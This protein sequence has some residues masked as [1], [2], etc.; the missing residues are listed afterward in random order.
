MTLSGRV[1][2]FTVVSL[3]GGK[4]SGVFEATDPADIQVLD[5][6]VRGRRGV[7]E[8]SAEIYADSIE[9]KKMTLPSSSSKNIVRLVRPQITPPVAMEE[10]AGVVLAAEKPKPSD[11]TAFQGDRDARSTP[12]IAALMQGRVK[13]L[14]PPKPF[15]AS[16]AKTE[17][18]SKRADRAK[19]RVARASVATP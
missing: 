4:A 19:V 6:A 17:K 10:K 1:I 14:N 8:I 15:A 16:E 18:A 11:Q 7:S 12:S 9:K 13:K 3:A 2:N 5:D